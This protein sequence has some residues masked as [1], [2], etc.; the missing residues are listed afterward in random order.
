MLPTLASGTSPLHSTKPLTNYMLALF[1][2]ALYYMWYRYPFQMGSSGTSPTYTDTPFSVQLVKYL[3]FFAIVGSNTFLA[4]LAR[5]SLPRY[6]LGQWM[7]FVM[8]SYLVVQSVNLALITGDQIYILCF[9][10]LF[11][12]VPL[13]LYPPSFEFSIVSIERCLH[14]FVYITTA[15]FITEVILFITVGR[16]PSLAFKGSYSV[17]FGGLWDDPNS[18]A[19][20]LSF[21]LPFIFFTNFSRPKKVLLLAINLVSLLATQSLTGIF[22]FVVSILIVIFCLF[23]K[24]VAI[25]QA[26]HIWQFYLSLVLAI[27]VAFLLLMYLE[28]NHDLISIATEYWAEKAGSVGGHMLS[29]NAL[30]NAGLSTFLGLAPTEFWWG[31]SGYIGILLNF[32]VVALVVFFL[33][34]VA[35]FGKAIKVLRGNHN[36]P[37]IAVF[38]GIVFFLVDYGVAMFNLPLVRVFPINLLFILFAMLVWQTSRISEWRGVNFRLD[39]KMGLNFLAH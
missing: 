2:L 7:A 28:L 20:F 35:V 26:R 5:G 39:N 3:L 27:I 36:K 23:L 8:A 9:L 33:I 18:F 10:F 14:W 13:L 38:Y 16:L 37:G 30:M 19:V 11:S 22:A 31:E 12:L 1:L 29:L 6:P 25:H 15:V 21:I 4:L 32:G 34:F 17:R 24:P